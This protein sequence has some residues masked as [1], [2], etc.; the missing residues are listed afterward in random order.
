MLVEPPALGGG[1]VCTQYGT[2]PQRSRDS[3]F[4]PLKIDGGGERG[5]LKV[6]EV[7]SQIK[8]AVAKRS[9]AAAD[10]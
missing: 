6:A 5:N 9:T 10:Q 7:V 2:A 3:P 8:A 4:Y 1:K